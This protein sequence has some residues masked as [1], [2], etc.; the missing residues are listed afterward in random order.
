MQLPSFSG[1][2]TEAF[3]QRLEEEDFRK[4]GTSTLSD[5]LEQMQL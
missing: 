4:E 1:S 5:L 3:L 2:K